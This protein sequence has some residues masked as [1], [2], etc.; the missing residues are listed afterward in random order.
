[1]ISAYRQNFIQQVENRISASENATRFGSSLS[2][3]SFEFMMA[4]GL[5]VV[6]VC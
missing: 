6:G 5:E 4:L 2:D 3:S 1:M